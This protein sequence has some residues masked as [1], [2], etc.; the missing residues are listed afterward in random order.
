[1]RLREAGRLFA[2]L[3]Q[4][5]GFE[6]P[7]LVVHVARELRLDIEVAANELRT[8][9][10]ANIDALLDALSGYL[11]VAE[12]A[13]LGG[14]LAWLREAE[15]REDLTPR[16]ED[17]QPGT[18]QV[19]TIHGAKG[20]EWDAVAVPRWVDDELPAKPLEGLGRLAR[21]RSLPLAGPRRRR[22]AAP[23]R[24]DRRSTRA[25]RSRTSASDSA[26]RSP[27]TTGRRSA[28]SPMSR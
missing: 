6:L 22:R 18:V 25:R 9:G 14:F 11:A 5:T 17:P 12:S 13:S 27:T 26:T 7:D 3:R 21:V 4:R 15:I 24:V 23:V 2:A 19:L 10:P 1:M 16:P 8:A 28:A 20:L